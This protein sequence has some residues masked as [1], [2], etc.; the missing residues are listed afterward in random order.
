[1]STVNKRSWRYTNKWARWRHLRKRKQGGTN[2]CRFSFCGPF[3]PW[4]LW[5]R[6]PSCTLTLSSFYYIGIGTLWHAPCAPRQQLLPSRRTKER[7]RME[8]CWSRRALYK[9]HTLPRRRVP[10]A[11]K[12]WISRS[13]VDPTDCDCLAIAPIFSKKKPSHQWKVNINDPLFISSLYIDKF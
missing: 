5:Q 7:N 12:M 13:S 6:V 2:R 10:S 4:V 8:R 9:R 11:F 3:L 1:M